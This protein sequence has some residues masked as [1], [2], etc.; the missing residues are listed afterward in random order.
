MLDGAVVFFAVIL[1]VGVAVSGWYHWKV[2]R[3]YK[4]EDDGHTPRCVAGEEKCH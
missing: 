4:H 3:G 1:T 2:W